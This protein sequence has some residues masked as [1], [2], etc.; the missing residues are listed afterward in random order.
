MAKMTREERAEIVRQLTENTPFNLD[1]LMEP[2]KARKELTELLSKLSPYG[3]SYC[4]RAIE[5]AYRWLDGNGKEQLSPEDYARIACIT[6]GSVGERNMVIRCAH[7]AKRL[8][9]RVQK[10]VEAI[11]K[12]TCKASKKAKKKSGCKEGK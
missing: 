5:Y 10:K 8:V 11:K 6:M 4:R 12:K 1:D 2:E 7:Y 3:L 9:D